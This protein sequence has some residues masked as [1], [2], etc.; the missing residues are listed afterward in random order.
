MLPLIPINGLLGV[1]VSL[2]PY[3][4]DFDQHLS[5]FM[6]FFPHPPPIA[7][8][9]VVVEGPEQSLSLSFFRKEVGG[10]VAK[11]E[12]PLLKGL[13]TVTLPKIEVLY[14]VK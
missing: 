5:L 3:E 4:S 7:H 2:F 1:S 12:L 9:L 14:H 8:H 10:I 13:H 6:I 11:N